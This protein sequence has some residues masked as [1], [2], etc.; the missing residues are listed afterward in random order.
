MTMF[1]KSCPK[2]EALKEHLIDLNLGTADWVCQP[3][4]T[5]V[6]G[7]FQ[8][9]IG[10]HLAQ[11]E[12]WSPWGNLVRKICLRLELREQEGHLPTV[13]LPFLDFLC[14]QKFFSKLDRK[15]SLYTPR[16]QKFVF[17]LRGGI[18]EDLWDHGLRKTCQECIL[19]KLRHEIQHHLQGNHPSSLE[20]I[21]HTTL[22]FLTPRLFQNAI[23]HASVVD[24]ASLTLDGADFAHAG[25]QHC[26][27][28]GWIRKPLCCLL[29]VLFCFVPYNSVISC[30]GHKK[31]QEI[32]KS[33]KEKYSTLVVKLLSGIGH[34]HG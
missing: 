31:Y 29:L 19:L 32:R 28:S 18:L 14:F 9:S 24:D 26:T 33:S 23:I 30:E 8:V 12:H 3:F 6:T 11:L 5:Y 22:P 7:N 2:K 1:W 27:D 20:H 21:N 13:G 15:K 4:V 25:F 34:V 17:H 10:C 16:L